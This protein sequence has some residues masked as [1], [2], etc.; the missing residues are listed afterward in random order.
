M[1]AWKTHKIASS[2]HPDRQRLRITKMMCRKM[3]VPTE[4]IGEKDSKDLECWCLGMNLLSLLEGVTKGSCNNSIKY[5]YIA[6]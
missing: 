5:M 1:V 3:S 2:S 6:K 4:V